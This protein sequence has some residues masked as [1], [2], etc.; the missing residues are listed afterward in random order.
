MSKIID[1]KAV[2][3]KVLAECLEDIQELKNAGVTPGLAVVLVG[4][5][6]ASKVYVGSKVRKCAE[7]GLHSRK[8]ELP[9]D[10]SQEDVLAV[11]NE[12]K[13]MRTLSSGRLIQ[14]RTLMVFTPSTSL[15]SPWRITVDLCHARQRDACA[16][17]RRP[18]LRLQGQKPLS[19]AVV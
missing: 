16:C 10:A 11:V 5:D 18:G 17:L 12:L 3:E 14:L 13:L 19:L 1:G 15:S 2:A 7:L 8:I 6:P 4:E 9:V